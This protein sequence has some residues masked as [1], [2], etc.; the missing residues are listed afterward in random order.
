MI[1][2]AR[3]IAESIGWLFMVLG[4]CYFSC[5]VWIWLIDK[6]YRDVKGI[7]MFTQ[8]MLRERHKAEWK[9]GQQDE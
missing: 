9:R 7:A 6:S 3:F 8:W 4:G 1:S 5:A 2:V